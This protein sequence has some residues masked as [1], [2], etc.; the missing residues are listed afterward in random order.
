VL[1]HLWVAEGAPDVGVLG[2]DAQ[3]LLRAAATD[4]RRMS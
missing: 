4:Q 1:E 3:G 2:D